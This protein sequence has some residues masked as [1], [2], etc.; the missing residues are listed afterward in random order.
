MHVTAGVLGTSQLQNS[1]NFIAARPQRRSTMSSEE[2]LIVRPG[3]RS[4]RVPTSRNERNRAARLPVFSAVLMCL[5]SFTARAA[6][7]SITEFD[8]LT[9]GG[10][11]GGIVAALDGN[12]WFT[13]ASA[14]KIGRITPNGIVTEFAAGIA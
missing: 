8:I 3:I 13:E 4:T 7:P 9:P 10:G 1:N 6:G 11:P 12:V 5:L 2:M 14:N